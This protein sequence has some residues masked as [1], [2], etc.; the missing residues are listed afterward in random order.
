MASEWVTLAV[1]TDTVC[2]HSCLIET[3]GLSVCPSFWKLK[4]CCKGDAIYTVIVA[5][6]WQTSDVCHIYSGLRVPSDFLSISWATNASYIC[7]LS[8][9][10]RLNT[11]A[12][13]VILYQHAHY[14]K[15]YR[16][17]IAISVYY[18]YSHF[19]SQHNYVFIK[20]EVISWFDLSVNILSCRRNDWEGRVRPQARSAI[21]LLVTLWDHSPPVQLVLTSRG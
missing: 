10:S 13:C 6:V 15:W 21:F 5:D 11:S 8:F 17:V 19:W 20:V 7:S 9:I 2:D 14:Q 4:I 12:K 3:D 16:G 1:N 18:K